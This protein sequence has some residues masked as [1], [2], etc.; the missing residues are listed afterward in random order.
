M[1]LSGSDTSCVPHELFELARAEL[2]IVRGE[3]SDPGLVVN[4]AAGHDEEDEGKAAGGEP[5][6]EPFTVSPDQVPPTQMDTRRIRQ[7]MCCHT[8]SC[9]MSEIHLTRS[10][11][12]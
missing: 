8:R 10:G 7:R 3:T 6:Q 1:S 11:N 2:S 5:G 12:G 9:G 4:V